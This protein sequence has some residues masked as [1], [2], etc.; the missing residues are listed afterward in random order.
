MAWFGY[1]YLF[2]SAKLPLQAGP[3]AASCTFHGNQGLTGEKEK[4]PMLSITPFST[5]EP[6]DDVARIKHIHQ[7]THIKKLTSRLH[8]GQSPS[9]SMRTS[10]DF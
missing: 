8:R 4:K 6:V 7:M 1:R 2:A 3:G 5:S 10:H 9:Y